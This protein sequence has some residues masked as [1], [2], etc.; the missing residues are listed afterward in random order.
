MGLGNN[1]DYK[2]NDRRVRHN[3]TVHAKIMDALVISGSS[4][5]AASE[6]AYKSLVAK[7]E[8]YKKAILCLEAE[9]LARTG[10]KEE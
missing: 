7:D 6:K 10:K 9:R 5:E 8:L 1:R 3:L 2:T 4:R